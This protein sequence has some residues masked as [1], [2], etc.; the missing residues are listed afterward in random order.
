MEPMKQ[1]GKA[2]HQDFLPEERLFRRFRSGDVVEGEILPSSLRFNEPPSFCRERYAKPEDTIHPNCAGSRDVSGFGVFA[3]KVLTVRI[4]I[5]DRADKSYLFL[6]VHK[7]LANCY[8]HSQVHCATSTDGLPPAS[9]PD[10]VEPPKEIRD[11]F[12]V[13]LAS[14]LSVLINPATPS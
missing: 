3:L 9:E 13:Q 1:E 10:H 8:A 6:P 5:K 12:R 11:A 7:P 4:E 2:A 14:N